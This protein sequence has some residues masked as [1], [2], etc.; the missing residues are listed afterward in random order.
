M[1][2]LLLL[3]TLLPFSNFAYQEKLDL[4]LS[5]PTDQAQ[6]QRLQFTNE[7]L[8]QVW[9]DTKASLPLKEQR[10]LWLLEEYQQRE[11]QRIAG[12]RI[13]YLTLALLFL[14]TLFFTFIFVLYRLQS[15]TS[16]E[17]AN[18]KITIQE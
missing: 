5:A 11:Q 1:T 3:F 10:K 15:Q 16:K 8:Q 12:D 18:L 6:A 13:F 9:A 14:I 2:K 4:F 7:E 17:L